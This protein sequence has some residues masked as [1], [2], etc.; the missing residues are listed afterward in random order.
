MNTLE[1]T[2]KNSDLSHSIVEKQGFSTKYL[3][4]K[5]TIYVPV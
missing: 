3:D 1:F 4:H 5:A 2:Q